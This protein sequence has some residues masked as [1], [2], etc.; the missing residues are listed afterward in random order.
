MEE[1]RANRLIDSTSPY[2]RQHAHNP[3]DWYPW[4]PEALERARREDRPIFL[5]IGYS[6]CHWCHVM[7][8]E[9]FEDPDIAAAMNEHFISIK[10]DREERPDLDE[11]YMNAV[12]AL[13]GSGGWPLSVFLTPDLKPFYGGTYFPPEDRGGRPG[14]MRLLQALSQ[15]YRQNQ[16][17]IGELTRK[18]QA[19][20]EALGQL[21]GEGAEPTREEVA[22]AAQT[23]ARHLD[24]RH[25]GLGTAPKFPRAL[26]LEFLF[27]HQRLSGEAGLLSQL[28]FGLEKMARGGIYDQLGGGFARYS[29]DE[30]WVVP[31]FEKMLYDNALLPPLYLAWL[32]LTGSDLARRVARETLDFVLRDLAAPNGGFYSGWDADSEGVEGK[33]YVWTLEEVEQVVGA[34]ALPLAAAALGVTRE[35]SFEGVNVLTRPFS[36]KELAARF[37]LKPEEVEARLNEALARL[38]QAREKRVK[39]HRDEKLITAWNALMV[40]ALAQGAQVLGD[41]RFYEAAATAARFILAQLLKPEGLYRIWSEGRVAVPGFSED[42]A[43]LALALLELFETDFDPAWLKGAVQLLKLMDDKFLEDTDGLYFYVARDQE[44]T[45]LRSKSVHDQTIPSGNSLAARVCLKLHCFTAESRYLDRARGILRRLSPQARENPGGFGHF[46]TAAALHLTP[47]LDLTLVGDPGSP[48]LKQMLA[49][50]YG[51]FLPERSLVVKN[52]A[53]CAALE[54][55]VPAARTYGPRD[56]PVA[57]LCHDFA[58]QPAIRDAGELAQRLARLLPAG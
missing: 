34:Q 33:F 25:G 27:H 58:C 46:W 16:R 31:H 29:V 50:I 51:R 56:V 15:A 40:T 47:P 42:Y 28:A 32:R 55:L 37:S 21:P 54:E 11:T 38:R 20:L 35:G 48:A 22:A 12:Y 7:A 14:F 24:P 57:Y 30:A 49:V 2:L 53:D 36:L 13:T 19:H 6:T 1:K 3:V 23:V 52:P 44:A 17:E 43:A 39:P 45:L 18:L 26:E 8:H 10:V 41:R 5:S 4:G 9:S